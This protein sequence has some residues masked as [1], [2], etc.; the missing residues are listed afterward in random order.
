MVQAVVRK[1]HH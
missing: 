1:T